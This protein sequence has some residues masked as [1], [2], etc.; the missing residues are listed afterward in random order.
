VK[1]TGLILA[2]GR[3]SRFG[4]DKRRAEGDWDGPLLHHILAL[5]RPHF[6]ELC[7]VI[8]PD[9]EFGAES[10]RLHAAKAVINPQPERGIGRSLALGVAALEC[11]GVV[12]GLC[13]MPWIS[14]DTIAQVRDALVREDR[15]V[16]P[17][18]G[19][20]IGFPRGIPSRY[21]AELRLLDGDRGAATVLDWRQACLIASEDP[22]ISR[23]IDRPED[24]NP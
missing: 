9:D 12:I 22:G 14:P 3:S 7:A 8:G 19:D 24:I 4:R 15:P 6:S 1:I 21:F 11:D 10:C 20:E 16:A 23:D 2:A 18:I 13:D 5:Y 17:A